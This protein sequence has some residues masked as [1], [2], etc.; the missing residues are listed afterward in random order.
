MKK[1]LLTLM[2]FFTILATRAQIDEDFS[3]WPP[4]GWSLT[5]DGTGTFEQGSEVGG[6]YL[7]PVWCPRRPSLGVG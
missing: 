4:T 3:T 1:L 7:P 2:C 5:S 6:L